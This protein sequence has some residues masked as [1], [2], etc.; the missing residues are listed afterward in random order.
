MASFRT[1]YGHKLLAVTCLVATIGVTSRVVHV[2]TLI[3]DKYLGDAVY[4]AVFYLV[5]SLMWREGSIT[6]KAILA[7]LYVVSVEIF[8]LTR[9]P[10]HLNQSANLA[11]RAFAYV[12]LGSAFSGWDML[13]YGVG[14]GGV[15]W[16]DKLC[17]KERVAHG[18]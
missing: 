18:R 6:A 11:V 5:L 4:A 7:T 14:I 9:I 15:A 10:A 1:S 2:G 8:Q 17:L 13:A 3:W 12:V 16:V